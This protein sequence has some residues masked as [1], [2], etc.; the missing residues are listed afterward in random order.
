M[1]NKITDK[2]K[3]WLETANK[4]ISSKHLPWLGKMLKIVDETSLLI[5]RTIF[6]GIILAA[7][8]AIGI[9]VFK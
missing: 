5:G 7:L 6:F 3:E 9:R 1:E 4:Y 2:E 8:A